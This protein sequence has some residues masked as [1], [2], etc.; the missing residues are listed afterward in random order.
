[1]PRSIPMSPKHHT[2]CL[3]PAAT[4]A[5]PCSPSWQSR[6]PTQAPT[7]ALSL[8]RGA[9]VPQPWIWMSVVSYSGKN[10]SSKK[11]E[12]KQQNFSSTF[13]G[14]PNPRRFYLHIM[15]I[16]IC[17]RKKKTQLYKFWGFFLFAKFFASR[18][19]RSSPNTRMLS[20]PHSYS[21]APAL[22]TYSLIL[23]K[24]ILHLASHQECCS[25]TLFNVF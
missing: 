24:L 4:I 19:M 5:P 9:A 2:S 22:F 11:Q 7:A 10:H 21:F 20:R 18:D 1:M 8:T 3:V 15:Q 17:F 6:S 12:K 13:T 16:R 14:L 25:S 23:S